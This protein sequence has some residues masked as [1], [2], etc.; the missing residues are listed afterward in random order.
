M[1][2]DIDF[3]KFGDLIKWPQCVVIG[4]KVTVEQAK[5]IIA[6]TDIFFFGFEGNNHSLNKTLY[7]ILNY[8]KDFN[9]SDYE[10]KDVG[11]A[12]WQKYLDERDK[13][14]EDNKLISTEYFGNG[15]ISNCYIGGVHGWCWPDGTIFDNQNIGKWPDWCEIYD[16]LS[17]IAE[18]FPFLK[19]KVYLFNQEC[20]CS[21][22]Y[23]YPKACVG[24]FAVE[25]GEVF[26]LEE[27]EWL[28]ADSPLC[29]DEDMDER[30]KKLTEIKEQ[31]FGPGHHI[32]SH[33]DFLSSTENFFTEDE[34]KT[35]F[36]G[37]FG[38]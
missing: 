38:I 34:F 14:E 9:F 20:G 31:L 32:T 10:D 16:D 26:Q 13:F 8:R 28:P 3:R 22:Y 29:D 1:T 24:G 27:N 4:E 37:Y 5:D 36:K 33:R 7:S 19:M 25:N 30:N 2:K 6:R 21:E 17:K 35:Y 23:N 12:E 11:R 15:W 18:S